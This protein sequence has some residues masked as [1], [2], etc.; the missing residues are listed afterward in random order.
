MTKCE[1]WKKV[2]LAAYICLFRGEEID[3]VTGLCYTASSSTENP[4]NL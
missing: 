3:I 1:E 4:A 2:W